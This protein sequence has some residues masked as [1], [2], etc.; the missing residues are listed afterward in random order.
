MIYTKENRAKYNKYVFGEEKEDAPLDT[1]ILFRSEEEKDYI[2]YICENQTGASG[3][4]FTT[5]GVSTDRSTQTK[6]KKTK[7]LF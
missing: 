5:N 7:Y 1:P 2:I 6:W 4:D 3:F